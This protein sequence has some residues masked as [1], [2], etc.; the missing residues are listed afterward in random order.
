MSRSIFKRSRII[1]RG[2]AAVSIT[3][4]MDENPFPDLNID[5][6]SILDAADTKVVCPSCGTKRRYFCYSC[7]LY[8]N[9]LEKSMP[10]VRVS[11]FAVCQEG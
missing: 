8:V 6:L 10:V 2:K 1:F 7:I 4:R 11:K 9:E 5:N 3:W